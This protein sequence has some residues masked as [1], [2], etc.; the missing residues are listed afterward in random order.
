[1]LA[2]Q[3]ALFVA[4]LPGSMAIASISV[5]TG[6]SLCAL[7]LLYPGRSFLAQELEELLAMSG[8][9]NV[10]PNHMFKFDLCIRLL[11]VLL[12]KLKLQECLFMLSC[13]RTLLTRGTCDC[14]LSLEPRTAL[15]VGV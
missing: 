2:R 3:G 7:L 10:A 4:S 12:P 9:S 13:G 14:S 8:Y 1:M 15:V 11:S 5:G 6:W